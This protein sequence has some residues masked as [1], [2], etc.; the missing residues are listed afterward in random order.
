MPLE[1]VS[2]AVL[3]G[4][5]MPRKNYRKQDGCWNC[6]H[7][8]YSYRDDA[9]ACNIDGDKPLHP[10]RVPIADGFDKHIIASMKYRQWIKQNIIDDYSICDSWGKARP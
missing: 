1:T 4:L 6:K 5:E 2:G 10:V 9:N 7:A 8:F 3:G